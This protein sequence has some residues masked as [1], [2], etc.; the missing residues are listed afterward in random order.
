MIKSN[1]SLPRKIKEKVSYGIACCRINN[2]QF[3][4]LTVRKR[5]TYAFNSFV[6][7]CYSSHD[8]QEIINLLSGM[9]Y[10]EKVDLLSLN[11]QYIW[12]KL[13]MGKRVSMS[14]FIAS[15]TK[16]ELAFLSDNGNRLRRL[17]TVSSTSN[18][19]WEIPKGKR[20]SYESSIDC[21]IRELY[22]EA[23]INKDK[24]RIFLE[25]KRHSYIDGDIKYTN[26]YYVAFMC[27]NYT[28]VI[29]FS[30][31]NQIVEVADIKWMNLELYKSNNN[32]NS[33]VEL[34]RSIF[35]FL[36]KKIG[37]KPTLAYYIV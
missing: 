19:I 24:Y 25:C 7:G 34:V 31:R 28:P 35:R 20:N 36:R 11:F 12:Y 21:A 15:R 17:I 4:I 22:E 18:Y 2:G 1:Q 33:S 10:E 16:F 8:N 26:I 9:T 37:I 30:N 3:E 5:I 13:W 23:G 6:N 32:H 27:A 29:D 14:H